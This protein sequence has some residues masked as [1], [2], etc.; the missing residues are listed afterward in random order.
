METASSRRLHKPR[1]KPG[2]SPTYEAKKRYN[3]RR[4]DMFRLQRLHKADFDA[5]YWSA[6]FD[7][8]T[9]DYKAAYF[10]YEVIAR[11][12]RLGLI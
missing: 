5:L 12:V 4:A 8:R 3:E 10:A 7:A 11:S 6:R 1:R 2:T 9:S